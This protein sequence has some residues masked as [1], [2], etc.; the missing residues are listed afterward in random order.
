[1]A[2]IEAEL[3]SAGVQNVTG[4]LTPAEIRHLKSME[5]RIERGLHTFRVVGEAL[6]DI[7]DNRLY[8]QTHPT[9]EAYC[10]DRWDMDRGRAYQFIAATEV[11]KALGAGEDEG[12]VNEAQARE[13]VVIARNSPEA[14][15]TVWEAAKATGKPV[16][17]AIL[18]EEARKVMEPDAPVGPTA[19]EALA[20]RILGAAAAYT[21]WLA[22]KPSRK[23]RTLI[24][25]AVA[26][27]EAATG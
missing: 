12:P 11:V 18:R 25:A 5:A 4:D 16:T 1:M 23:E 15:K 26:K 7:R 2:V 27:F 20:T 10:R 14:V 21:R 8:R 22:T 9:F 17:A 6:M 3:T 13:L 24:D 19:A